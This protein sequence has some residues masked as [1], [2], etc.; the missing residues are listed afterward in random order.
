MCEIQGQ[1]QWSQLELLTPQVKVGRGQRS[2]TVIKQSV[3][4]GGCGIRDVHSLM[5]ETL[6]GSLSSLG[7][8][9][10]A[11]A[12]AGTSGTS[13]RSE[14]PTSAGFVMGSSG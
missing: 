11:A 10:A 3:V 13:P 9:S 12:A 5:A 8:H 2:H 6:I 7:S 1:V 4:K 14:N